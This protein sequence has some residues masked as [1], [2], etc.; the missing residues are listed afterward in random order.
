MEQADTKRRKVTVYPA[1]SRTISLFS[2]S[3]RH[4]LN[5]KPGGNLL[6][7]SHV[8]GLPKHQ[9][10]GRM[11]TWPDELIMDFLGY[12][13]DIDTIINLSHTSRVMYAFCYD[14]DLWKRLFLKNFATEPE[15]WYG[16]WRSTVLGIPVDK[17]ANLQLPDNLHC[18][19]LLYR[20]FQCSQINYEKVFAKIISEEKRYHYDSIHDTL[21][22]LP[23]GRI[24][25]FKEESMTLNRFSESYHDA[26]F[27]LTNSTASRW[28]NWNMEGLLDRFS[29]IKFRQEAVEWSLSMYGEYLKH[30]QDENPLYLFDCK[31][32]AMKTLVKEYE[33]PQI[34]QDDLFTVFNSEAG[35]CRPDHAWLIVGP[36]R[37][38][39][40][41]HK[42]P[43]YTSAWNAAL[44]GRKL[45]IMLPPDITPPGVG[46]D[47]EESEV[48]SPVGI[49][50]W[51]I[52]GF[53]NDS[54]K[55]PECQIG[56]T[57]PGECM[58][59]P[60]G[61]WHSVINIDDSVALT[62][63]FVP[64]TKLPNAL[65]FLKNKRDQ[66]SGFHPNQVKKV[67]DSILETND[68]K[69]DDL[70]ILQEYSTTFN[71]LNIDGDEDCGE[72]MCSKL[73]PLPIFELFKQLLI[74]NGKRQDLEQGLKALSKIEI[75][76]QA[77]LTGKSKKWE[78]LTSNG[79]ASA[80]SFNFEDSDDE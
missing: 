57:F 38:G 27:I 41:F 60:S 31:S 21:G 35:N 2:T 55:I 19:D 16:S 5:V 11:A 70:N 4:P 1:T 49:A 65:H 80:F 64:N 17:Q 36:A 40:T 72:I 23:P 48:T 67:L 32:T 25:R 10:L 62:Q 30:N 52:S 68:E 73:P 45:W 6:L 59:V 78:A 24:P 61:W 77:S 22:S 33:A 37:S 43:N 58:Y 9:Q 50:E 8:D 14:E 3:A 76:I 51:V 44:T 71:S 12:I 42:D 74:R 34:F 20:P 46:T 7:A 47:D 53:F 15:K 39:S 28:P 29:D 69:D 75:K 63:N 26:P 79:T 66:L 56:I 54:V 13:D 18:S